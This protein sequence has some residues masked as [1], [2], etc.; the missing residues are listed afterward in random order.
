MDTSSATISDSGREPAMWIVS[1]GIVEIAAHVEPRDA[2]GV[3][4]VGREERAVE[5]VGGAVAV[6]GDET[7]VGVDRDGPA[8]D[9]ERHRRRDRGREEIEPA[10]RGR[11][12]GS[13]HDVQHVVAARVRPRAT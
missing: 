5:A 6:A 10:D 11:R 3:V 12:V 9:V 2:V 13:A 8:A 1:A 7:G 4:D